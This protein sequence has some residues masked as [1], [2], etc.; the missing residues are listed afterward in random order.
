[1]FIEIDFDPN[2]P[3]MLNKRHIS[4]DQI[5]EAVIFGPIFQTDPYMDFSETEKV[6]DEELY[7]KYKS[8]LEKRLCIYHLHILLKTGEVITRPYFDNRMADLKKIYVTLRQNSVI[9]DD[10]LI[11]SSVSG[12]FKLYTLHEEF[13]EESGNIKSRKYRQIEIETSADLGEG[14]Y[15]FWT[16]VVDLAGDVF[17]TLTKSKN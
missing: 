12:K 6:I 1:M 2:E 9:I 8:T 3:D 10:M 17:K 14:K 13:Y 11:R 7:Q 16:K 4:L 5:Q 15:K